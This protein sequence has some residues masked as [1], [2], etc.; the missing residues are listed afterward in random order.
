[1]LN[2]LIALRNKLQPKGFGNTDVL[3]HDYKFWTEMEKL[4]KKQRE[5]SLEVL[6]D[7]AGFKDGETKPGI[8]MKSVKYSTEFKQTNPV[9]TFDKEIFMDSIIA[10]Y[11]EIPRHVLRELATGAVVDGVVRKSFIVEEL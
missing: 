3:Q 9:K 6:K 5:K 10:K 7:A 8:I 11:P 4:S 2:D 1:M